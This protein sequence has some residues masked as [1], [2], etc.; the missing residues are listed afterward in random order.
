VECPKDNSETVPCT[1][2][3]CVPK[4][5]CVMGDWGPWGPCSTSCTQK[6]VRSV[7][8]HPSDGGTP[9]PPANANEQ[10]RDCTGGDCDY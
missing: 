3:K 8:T 5:D 7:E 9:C 6:R 10:K 1:G 4:V 2:G